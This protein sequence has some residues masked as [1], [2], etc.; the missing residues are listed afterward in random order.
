[1]GTQV[2]KFYA[3]KTFWA[4]LI[5]IIG[6]FASFFTGEQALQEVSIIVIGGVFTLLRFWTNK[7][8]VL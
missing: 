8:I 4:G 7:A 3:S 6:G 2:K 1:M 5:T